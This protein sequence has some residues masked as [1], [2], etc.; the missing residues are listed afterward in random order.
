[1]LPIGHTSTG[2][3]ISQINKSKPSP[4]VV[5]IYIL[6]ANIFDIDIILLTLFNRPSFI[7]HR[8][9]TH[10]PLF[11]I[12]YFLFFLFIIQKKFSPRQYFLLFLAIISHLVLDSLSYL[13]YPHIVNHQ[14]AWFYPFYDPFNVIN[15]NLLSNTLNYS[16]DIDTFTSYYFSKTIVVTLI[17]LLLFFLATN[18]YYQNYLKHDRKT[19]N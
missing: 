4:K 5:L 2:F 11:G 16:L 12:I 6:A 14:I 13:I 7:H 3:L 9:P 17:E 10:T 8:L 19:I 15:T 1:M 18:V